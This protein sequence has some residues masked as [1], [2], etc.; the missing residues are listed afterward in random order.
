MGPFHP[1]SAAQA[2]E[3]IRLDVYLTSADE[4]TKLAERI[5]TRQRA[6]KNMRDFL[7][8]TGRVT[9]RG[10]AKAAGEEGHVA[11]ASKVPVG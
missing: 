2:R 8:T 3:S 6:A 9:G 11:P 1:S 10:H 5:A 4:T 7:S